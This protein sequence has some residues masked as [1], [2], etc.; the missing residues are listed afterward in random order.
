MVVTQSPLFIV[1]KFFLLLG[2]G[3]TARR[4][5]TLCSENPESSVSHVALNTTLGCVPLL[6]STS[7][8]TCIIYVT[9]DVQQ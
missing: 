6:H 9:V 5:Q 2:G 4:L 3:R 7:V 1:S 8:A